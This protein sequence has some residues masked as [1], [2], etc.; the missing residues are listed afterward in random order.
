MRRHRGEI[1]RE[2]D[3]VQW[4]RGDDLVIPCWRI[5]TT[6]GACAESDEGGAKRRS[7]V[8]MAWARQMASSGH[9]GGAAERFDFMTETSARA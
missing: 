2:E 1:P 8:V 3:R 5:A 6:F 9:N 7:W 4:R